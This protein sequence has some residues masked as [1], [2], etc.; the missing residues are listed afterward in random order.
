LRP[1]RVWQ[2]RVECR[3]RRRSPHSGGRSGACRRPAGEL[4]ST[5]QEPS[6]GG[7]RSPSRQ[8]AILAHATIVRSTARQC[9]LPAELAPAESGP[10]EVST[11]PN[12]HPLKIGKFHVNSVYPA[13]VQ[14]TKG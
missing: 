6:V 3:K 11:G 2:P 7:I 9:A 1:A 12:R 10:A 5:N 4:K 8:R 14:I 13:I